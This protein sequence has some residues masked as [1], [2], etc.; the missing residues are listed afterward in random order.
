MRELCNLA[1][2]ALSQGRD[3]IQMAELEAALAPPEQKREIFD[4]VN[5]ESMASLGMAPLIPIRKGAK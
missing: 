4:K 5:A 3:R 1:Y 2:A